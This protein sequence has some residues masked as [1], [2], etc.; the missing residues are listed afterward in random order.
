MT[1]A[2]K[3][4]FGIPKGWKKIP[5]SNL[6]FFI[7]GVSSIKREDYGFGTPFITYKNIYSHSR[8]N[9]NELALM[10][11]KAQELVKRNCIYGDIFFTASSETMDEV[12]ISSVLLDEVENLTF[13]GFCKRYRLHHFN[14]ILPEYLRYYLRSRDFRI[15]VYEMVT[16]DTRFNISQASLSQ[17][18][19]IKPPLHEQKSIA[20]IL[21]TLDDKIELNRQMN[22]TLEAMAHALF[23]DWFVNFAP[24]RAK[25]SNRSPYL[26]R[27]V[28]DLFP[29]KLDN[30]GKPQGW[31]TSTI[32][33]E[34]SVFDGTT[35]S[36]KE[37]SYWS[38][39]LHWATPKDLSKLHMPILLKT[40]RK[41]TTQG[42]SQINSGLLPEGAVLLSSGAPIGYLAIAMIPTAIGTR[43][44]GMVCQNRL[45]NIFVW[46][47]AS[48][49][50]E[51]IKQRGNGSVFPQISKK[52]FCPI[53]LFVP[54]LPILS[55]FDSAV[56]P[57]FNR[58]CNN[59]RELITLI[60]TRDYLL[61]KLISGKVRTN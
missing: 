43:T 60:V 6:G 59:E 47:W 15:A 10:N 22:K 37:K 49:N 3:T 38:G 11:V 13:N 16:G 44:F 61:P 42:L 8:V 28:W 32:G 34:V 40:E 18:N 46:L 12:A 55:A 29:N 52:H 4:S 20:H 27:E 1:N 45:S 25:M 5:M 56:R 24:T 9:I 2:A 30:E 35:P 39:N 21:G 53:P 33:E 50:I 54:P 26:A 7:G 51:T 14:E 57:I 23:K 17:L 58:I 36:T 48:A 41:I 19:I 31:E